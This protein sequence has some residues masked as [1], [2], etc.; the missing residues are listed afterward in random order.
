MVESGER[1]I[2]LRPLFPIKLLAFEE[3]RG[4]ERERERET[5]AHL[6]LS[7]SYAELDSIC[8]CSASCFC[9]N[10]VKHRAFIFM[11]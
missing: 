10:T 2:I 1:G 11:R 3:E 7:D 6:D 9:I 8:V 5:M 4:R